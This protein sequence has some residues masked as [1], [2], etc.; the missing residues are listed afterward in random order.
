MQDKIRICALPLVEVPAIFSRPHI[1]GHTSGLER[2]CSRDV[3]RVRTAT[4]TTEL[5][6]LHVL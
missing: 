2:S 4:H 1:P 6:G 5:E 3:S